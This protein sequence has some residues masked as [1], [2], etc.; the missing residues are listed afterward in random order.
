V[1]LL[2]ALDA[3]E[4]RGVERERRRGDIALRSLA[5]LGQ[6]PETLDPHV[7]DFESFAVAEGGA[8]EARPPGS[9]PDAGVVWR[10]DAGPLD[11]LKHLS[12][13][14]ERLTPGEQQAW[15]DLEAAHADPLFDVAWMATDGRRPFGDVVRATWLE[16]GR[17]EPEALAQL[18]DWA[19]RTGRAAPG[20]PTAS[21]RQV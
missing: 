4:P 12:S 2:R 19:R 9:V 7:R 14:W 11:F 15:R 18:F 3:G 21:G 5:R 20:T 10:R 8:E 13:G 1:R 17:W 6:N 16:T